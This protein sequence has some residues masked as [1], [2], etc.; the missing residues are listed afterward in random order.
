MLAKLAQSFVCETNGR[1]VSGVKSVELLLAPT[2]DIHCPSPSGK[3]V[4]LLLAST[5]DISRC[6]LLL[7]ATEVLS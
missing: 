3:P 1:W 4:E 7:A 2:E 5:E 6:E